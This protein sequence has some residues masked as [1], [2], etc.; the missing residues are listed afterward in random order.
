MYYILD[1][2]IA[3]RS[4]WLVPYAFYVRHHENA[5]G[6]KKNEFDLLLK[7]D[8]LHDLDEN[9]P[10]VNLMLKERMIYPCKKG[11]V[12][13]N[14]W[15]KH[16]DC[17]NRYMPKMNW[18]ITG[19]CNYNCLHCFNAADNAPLQSE[20]SYEDALKLLDEARECGINAFTLTGGE[21]MVHRHFMDIVRAIYE[22]GMYI[23]ELNTNGF[24]I[25]QEVLDEFKKLDC[26]PLMKISFDGLG[27]HDWMRNRKGAE[28]ETL[29]AIKLCIK[30]NFRVM[31][32][33]QFNKQNKESI[34][35]TLKYL[36]SIGVYKTR[37]IWT[38]PAPRWEQNASGKTFSTEEYYNEC[39]NLMEEYT[40]EK[41]KMDLIFWQF[42]NVNV[43][44]NGYEISY[45]KGD[46]YRESLPLCRGNRGMIAIS[47]S[48][49]VFPCL[50]MSGYFE[51]LGKNW[52]NVKK[53]GLKPLLQSSDYLCEV[54]ATIKD[55]TNVNNKCSNCKWLK[56]CAGGCRALAIL[57]SSGNTRGSDLTKCL[58]YN[59]GYY[60]KV[61]EL[62]NKVS[63]I[64]NDEK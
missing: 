23:F 31:V 37:I 22:R 32:Q 41:H 12:K 56:Y 11:E 51:A 50:Q 38:S 19:K 53:D 33:M 24:Y 47:S 48:G 39:L 7:C 15:Q 4:F 14:E 25:T 16:L 44:Q 27:Y 30:N 3:L 36:D 21:P 18:M 61:K 49:D 43:T 52:G 10:L 34:L 1:P 28:E 2:N 45:S 26:W 62:A 29:K 17:D 63:N 54:C 8:G 60:E 13:L 42:S 58:F 46:D 59:G 35:P 20:W 9:D 55:L 40:K 6:L 64:F 57:Y 5:I